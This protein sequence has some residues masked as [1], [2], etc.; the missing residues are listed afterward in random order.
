MENDDTPQFVWAYTM[1]T[2]ITTTK[3]GRCNTFKTA[4]RY[5]YFIISGTEGIMD[6]NAKCEKENKRKAPW[7]KKPKF[8]SLLATGR[9]QLPAIYRMFLTMAIGIL[10]KLNGKCRLLVYMFF[11]D[12]IT[13]I[14]AKSWK[15]N[16]SEL[17]KKIKDDWNSILNYHKSASDL[18]ATQKKLD[19]TF[20]WNDLENVFE[21]MR[22]NNKTRVFVK[23]KRRLDFEQEHLANKIAQ[24]EKFLIALQERIPGLSAGADTRNEA[25]FPM[26]GGG[27]FTDEILSVSLR[28]GIKGV[29][30]RLTRFF[31]LMLSIPDLNNGCVGEKLAALRLKQDPRVLAQFGEEKLVYMV[32][33]KETW[34]RDADNITEKNVSSIQTIVRQFHE[35]LERNK[36]I[37]GAALENY[38]DFLDNIQG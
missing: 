37:P 12:F 20:G 26:D 28:K 3:R 7:Y 31:I 14:I 1:K 17:K 21:K 27:Q 5:I 38:K 10:W 29:I 36:K 32:D 34:E 8:L 2:F 24:Q 25:P 9:D 6:T 4:L 33:F 16:K 30:R 13:S 23:K 35:A 15:T 11:P 22:K 19:D 18:A